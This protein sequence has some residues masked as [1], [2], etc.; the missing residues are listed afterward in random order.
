MH[1]AL[2]DLK[3]LLLADQRQRLRDHQDALA[4]NPDDHDVQRARVGPSR[5]GFGLLDGPFDAHARAIGWMQSDGQTWAHSVQP[6]QAAESICTLCRP[7]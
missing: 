6:M 5:G 3:A 7:S 2:L 4:A 1:F